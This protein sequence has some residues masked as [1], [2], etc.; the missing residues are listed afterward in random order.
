MLIIPLARKFDWRR[1]PL[2]TLLLILANV[3]VHVLVQGKDDESGERAVRYFLDSPLAQIEPIRYLQYL[4]AE[5]RLKEEKYYRA[6]LAKDNSKD[7]SKEDL[8][9]LEVMSAIQRDQHFLWLLRAGQ[10]VTP[11][12]ARYAEWR[13]ARQEFDRLWRDRVSYRYGFVPARHDGRSFVTHQFLHGGW[14]H[15]IGNM[16]LLL[17]VGFIVEA[18]LGW[19]LFLAGYLIC[20]VGAAALFWALYP[21]SAIPLI[22]AS[23]AVSGVVGM[24][25]AI[26][27]LR[28][29]NFFYFVWVYFDYVKA[30]ALIVLALWLANEAFQLLTNSESGIAYGAHIGG[31]LCG[32]LLVGAARW[33]RAA[34]LARFLAEVDEQSGAQAAY[35][36]AL[37]L[38]GEL[39]FGEACEILDRLVE[40]RPDDLELVVQ[41]YNVAKHTPASEAYHRAARRVFAL[42]AGNRTMGEIIGTTFADYVVNAKPAPSIAPA[43]ALDL[44]RKLAERGRMGEG[45]RLAQLL[46]ERPQA[47]PEVAAAL[48]SLAEGHLSAGNTERAKHWLRYVAARFP[49]SPAAQRAQSLSSAG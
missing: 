40:Q 44:A 20:G 7:N 2:I 29:I 39:R 35:R 15:L 19:W 6:V 25:T 43:V 14:D 24:Y 34:G 45:E 37:S 12:E 38:I 3:V 47:S 46:A 48:V 49:G 17:V 9:V 5:G 32:A 10:I 8:G 26:F 22:G 41:A 28:R 21:T 33:W 11:S 27:G 4:H 30:P 18:A 13:A 23:G 1:P 42:P 31:L 36:R 16:V